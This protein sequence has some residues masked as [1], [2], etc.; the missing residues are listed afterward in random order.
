MRLVVEFVGDVVGE[1]FAG[2]GVAGPERFGRVEARGVDELGHGHAE[3][4]DLTVAFGDAD[5]GEKFGGTDAGELVGVE[6][7]LGCGGCAE[8]VGEAGDPVDALLAGIAIRV[9]G[10]ASPGVVP[11]PVA[12]GLFEE[13]S[14]VVGAVRASPS[15]G[16]GRDGGRRCRC[17][18]S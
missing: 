17:A 10:V 3:G 1:A 7:V 9:P 13:R 15:N 12:V 4:E 18:G 8:A 6:E 14:G 5:A 2:R 11:D 16:A